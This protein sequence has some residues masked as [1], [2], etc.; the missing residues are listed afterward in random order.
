MD[1]FVACPL[2]QE[3]EQRYELRRAAEIRNRES[4]Y[5]ETKVYDRN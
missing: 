4:V 2:D 5:R 3:R 1:G